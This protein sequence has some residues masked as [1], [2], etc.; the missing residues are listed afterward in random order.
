MKNTRMW[1]IVGI[2]LAVVLAGVIAIA[3]ISDK[4]EP[5]IEPSDSSESTAETNEPTNTTESDISIP[6]ID[7][8]TDSPDEIDEPDNSETI[9]R[10]DVDPE[11]IVKPDESM[12][13]PDDAPDVSEPDAEPHTIPVVV[14]PAIQ[15]EPEK[16]PE[17][18]SPR[19]IIGGG[20]QEEKYNCGVDGHH[21]EGP[22]T[23]AYI[24]NLELQGCKYC[25][26][27]NCPSFY[28][29]DTWGNAQYTP[30]LCPKY[31]ATQDPLNFCSK[32]GKP[33]GDGKNGTC[34]HYIQECD[35]PNCGQHVGSRECHTCK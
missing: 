8:E 2:T 26:S 31:G 18:T 34:V 30:S 19:I 23:H 25:G 21:C 35:C 27:H 1:I 17:E 6:G 7:D 22:E 3:S 16:D 4:P 10:E 13:L 12:D 32:C 11:K 28:G 5:V 29:T 15:K 20:D 9:A 24:S 33:T 14:Q